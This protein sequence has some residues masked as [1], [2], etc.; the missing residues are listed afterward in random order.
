MG[1][2]TSLRFVHTFDLNRIVLAVRWS[3]KYIFAPNSP[4]FRESC[5]EKKNTNRKAIAKR[6]PLV[7]AKEDRY[8]FEQKI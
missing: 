3:V 1:N 8:K 6:Y 5:D 4:I 7:N 2:S